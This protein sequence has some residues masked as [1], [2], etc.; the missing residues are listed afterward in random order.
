MKSLKKSETTVGVLLLDVP[1]EERAKWDRD[2]PGLMTSS[3][4]FAFPLKGEVVQEGFS[5]RIVR[6][7][8]LTLTPHFIEA[9][10][11]LERQGVKA[12]VGGCGFM[13]LFQRETS[14][15]VSVPVF[16]SSLM[17]VPLVYRMLRE[18]QKVGILTINSK[19]LSEK[20]FNGAGWSSK[21]IPISVSGVQEIES[22]KT[23]EKEE[24]DLKQM[25][26]DLLQMAKEFV[27]LNPD[28]GAI[29]LECTLMPPYADSIRKATELPVFDIITLTKMVYE[30]IKQVD[31]PQ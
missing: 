3:K 19:R 14:R 6:D 15:A 16:T 21:D 2:T 12:V 7:G 25:G 13:V 29:V 9:A 28:I 22:W 8:D 18:N 5:K 30:G 10:Q 1:P 27:Q 24:L 4:T 26:I 23:W 11:K 20:H 17:L 31:C